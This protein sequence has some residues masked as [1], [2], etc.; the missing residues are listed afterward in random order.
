MSKMHSILHRLGPCRT[1]ENHVEVYDGPL[2]LHAR[3]ST[4][5]DIA[6]MSPLISLQE[7]TDRLSFQRPGWPEDIEEDEAMCVMSPP[8]QRSGET[9][10]NKED[11][12]SSG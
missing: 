3:T 2:S 5:D 8:R 11:N 12:K 6:L 10:C 4:A 7:K 1:M 9:I